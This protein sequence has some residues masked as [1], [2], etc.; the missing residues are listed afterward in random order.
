MA[1]YQRVSVHQTLLWKPLMR[2][3]RAT[4]VQPQADQDGRT[5]CGTSRLGRPTEN[6]VYQYLSIIV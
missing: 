2:P 6:S 3:V 4:E 1:A 5:L